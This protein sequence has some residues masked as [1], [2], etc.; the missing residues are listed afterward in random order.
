MA[1]RETFEQLVRRLAP[2]ETW[3]QFADRCGVTSRMLQNYNHGRSKRPHT[4]TMRALGHALGVD[5]DVVRKAIQASY[6]AAQ[7]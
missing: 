2:G 6:E 7:G 4:V 5:E 3:E 1:R